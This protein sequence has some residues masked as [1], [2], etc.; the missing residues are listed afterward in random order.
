MTD[1]EQPLTLCAHGRGG[2]RRRIWELVLVTSQ[3][4]STPEP[5]PTYGSNRPNVNDRLLGRSPL[6]QPSSS[7]APGL[8]N[9]TLTLTELC[10]SHVPPPTDRKSALAGPRVRAL[11][12]LPT[13]TP[14]APFPPAGVLILFPPTLGATSQVSLTASHPETRRIPYEA[15]LTPQLHSSSLTSTSGFCSHSSDPLVRVNKQDSSEVTEPH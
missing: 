10:A 6:C 12:A 7:P 11:P 9:A 3:E 15:S 1:Q 4:P 2:G 13:S 5:R 8:G 14:T